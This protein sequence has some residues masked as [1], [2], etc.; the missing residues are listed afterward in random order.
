MK[1]IIANKA[2]EPSEIRV[3]DPKRTSPA[4]ARAELT[5]EDPQPIRDRRDKIIRNLSIIGTIQTAII[6]LQWVVIYIM[7]PAV[8]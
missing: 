2:Y 5:R 4:P 8:R 1:E 6:F 3:I 7:I